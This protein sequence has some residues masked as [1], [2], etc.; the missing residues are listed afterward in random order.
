[1]MLEYKRIDLFGK[2]LFE[3]ATIQPPFKVPN[4][5]NN[6]ACFLHIKE[7]GYNSISE[8]EFITINTRQSVLMKCGNYVGQ[9]LPDKKT[10]KYQAVAVHFHPEVLKKIYANDIPSFLVNSNTKPSVSNMALMEASIP[11]DKYVE[12]ILFYFANPHLVNKD[13]L[14]LKTKEIILLLMQTQNAP[15][16]L[17]ILEN[18]FTKRTV[19]FKSTIESHLFSEIS[20]NELAQLNH[21]SISSFKRKFKATYGHPPL[22]YILSRRLEKSKNLLAISD[23]SIGDIAFSCG[24]KTI[25]H[26]S[27]KFKESYQISPSQYRLSLSDK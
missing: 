12:D 27:K 19:D 2:L 24:F 18:L 26:F 8:D 5:M 13:I 14:I 21:M 17:Q 22:Q 15:K 4:P 10:G 16:V 9:M 11:V 25:N 6:E 3:T 23:K 7:G 1:M 20:I